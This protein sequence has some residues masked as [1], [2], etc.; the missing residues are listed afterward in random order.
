MTMPAPCTLACPDTHAR[1]APVL[2]R[3][4]Q[5]E[6]P[7][8]ASGGAD[9]SGGTPLSRVDRFANNILDFANRDRNVRN[10]SVSI[11]DTQ[12]PRPR[13]STGTEQQH[14]LAW[15]LNP[16]IVKAL[17]PF[18][19]THMPEEHRFYPELPTAQQFRDDGIPFDELDRIVACV[20]DTLTN[21]AL[22]PGPL[23]KYYA[24]S[25]T[26]VL[27]FSPVIQAWLVQ[28]L[29]T[30]LRD[31]LASYAT[32]RYER[33]R[34]APAFRRSERIEALAKSILERE[35]EFRQHRETIL[36]ASAGAHC[37]S[38]F[39]IR[40]G[41]SWIIA[42]CIAM[43]LFDDGTGAG[44]MQRFYPPLPTREQFRADGHAFD[45]LEEI[46]HKIHIA[47][48]TCE[49]PPELRDG[50]FYRNESMGILSFKQR[51]Q[52]WLLDTLVP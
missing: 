27:C 24:D 2:A 41:Y 16:V 25:D 36:Q 12:A 46:V 22:P 19:G 11:L 9:A 28:H 49:L 5:A 23:I 42:P 44:P 43:A 7:T 47:L 38:G 21:E 51:L 18:S 14:P 8:D 32:Q 20:R 30:A 45:E 13:P 29:P 33:R 4:Q 50:W 40:I 52:E 39:T 10:Y 1:D 35:G 26:G 31:A 37:P 48:D 15:I 17:F 3:A 34:A 6:Q